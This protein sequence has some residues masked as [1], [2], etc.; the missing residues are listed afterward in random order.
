MV[1]AARITRQNLDDKSDVV[2]RKL[3]MSAMAGRMVVRLGVLQEK[4]N[5]ASLKI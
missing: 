4:N 2:V 3:S 1:R 5:V